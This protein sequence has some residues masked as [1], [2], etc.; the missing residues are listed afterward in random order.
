[1]RV[2]RLAALCAAGIGLT[3][4]VAVSPASASTSSCNTG[5]NAY[6]SMEVCS[7]PYGGTV[8]TWLGEYNVHGRFLVW[9][10]DY[11]A[12]NQ[13]S[14]SQPRYW[15]YNDQTIKLFWWDYTCAEFLVPQ[16]NGTEARYGPIACLR[17]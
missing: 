3:L 4:L 12:F 5:S 9:D 1:M 2:R 16:G 10:H 7:D 15:V 11:P 17:P 8:L 13:Y 14:S 6:F